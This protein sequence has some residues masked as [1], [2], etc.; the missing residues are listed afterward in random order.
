M[1]LCQGI[2]PILEGFPTVFLT[3][4]PKSGSILRC[5]FRAKTSRR[6][7]EIQEEEERANNSKNALAKSA[8]LSRCWFIIF[9]IKLCLIPGGWPSVHQPSGHV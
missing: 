1:S 4:D 6:V 7:E 9:D 2:S 3:S 8:C 5:V